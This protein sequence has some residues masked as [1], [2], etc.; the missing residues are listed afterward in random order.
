MTRSFFFRLLHAAVLVAVFSVAASGA[1]AQ[2]PADNTHT[3]SVPAAAGATA[4]KLPL[5]GVN[6]AARVG[7]VLIRGAQPTRQGFAAL[8]EAG[9]TTIVNL[10]QSGRGVQWERRVARSFGFQ[11]V[12]IP[13]RGWTPP[14][15]AQVARFLKL[16]LDPNQRV[17]VHCYYGD[18]RTGVM[19]ATY[20][21][22]QQHWAAEDAIKEMYSFGF[23]YYLYPSMESYAR[24]FP[25]QFAADSIFAPFRAPVPVPAPAPASDAK[26]HE[27]RQNR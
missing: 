23:H 8:K 12:H 14:S 2:T 3:R 13:V 7:D 26:Q 24:N 16:F 17:F 25:Q 21:M 11:F 22:A 5:A 15:D 20:R 27:S 18:D 1:R 9:V 6:N 4:Q 19:V 10:R